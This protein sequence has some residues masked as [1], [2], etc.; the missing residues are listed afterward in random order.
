MLTCF[1]VYI[2]VIVCLGPNISYGLVWNTTAASTT[3]DQS[4]S[5]IHQV[6][7]H[8]PKA[9]RKCLDNGR[10]SNVDITQC[11]VRERSPLILFSVYL[12]ATSTACNIEKVCKN[13]M[14]L[15]VKVFVHVRR[16]KV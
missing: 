10:W 9:T 2:F 11:T 16:W 7:W 15:Q 1:N 3:I 5:N 12:N 8:G 4:C 13:F 14:Q 6:F